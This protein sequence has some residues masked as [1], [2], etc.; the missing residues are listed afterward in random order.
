MKCICFFDS[1]QIKIIVII[2]KNEASYLSEGEKI[3][4]RLLTEPKI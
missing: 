4:E 2:L 1:L 3:F